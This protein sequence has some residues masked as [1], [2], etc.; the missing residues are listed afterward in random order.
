[1][2]DD[3]LVLKAAEGVDY[4]SLPSMPTPEDFY[5]LSR[6]KGE[7]S[8][9][10]L[11][12]ASGWGKD[13]AKA[14]I[15]KLLE[16]G[17]LVSDDF[18]PEAAAPATPEA[19]DEPAGESPIQQE[20]EVAE[21]SPVASASQTAEG[22]AVDALGNVAGEAQMRE[23]EAT[24]ERTPVV[25]REP[26]SAEQP[27]KK[28]EP[29]R[30]HVATP[31][32]DERVSSFDLPVIEE[33]EDDLFMS[34]SPAH[35]SRVKS[36]SNSDPSSP[37]STRPFDDGKDFASSLE[38][39]TNAGDDEIDAAAAMS[40]LEDPDAEPSFGND[41]NQTPGEK[42]SEPGFAILDSEVVQEEAD[43]ATRMLDPTSLDIAT[44]VATV[45]SRPVRKNRG[46]AAVG[47]ALAFSML[48]GELS[49]FKVAPELL[50]PALE[51]DPHARQEVAYV[52]SAIGKVTHYE[53]FGVS[54]EA[55]RKEI[56]KAYF[57]L[58]KRFHPDLYF[59]K[60]VGPFG[61]MVE[62]V[63]KAVTQAY[64]VLS[65]RKKRADYDQQ[66]K[67]RSAE[68][69]AAESQS[70]PMAEKRE[71]ARELLIKRASTHHA[72]GEFI[73][74]A[75]ALRK[76]ITIR[77]EPDLLVKLGNALYRAN[78]RLDDAAKY[79][80]SALREDPKNLDGMLV[81]AK[82]LERNEAYEDA[83]RVLERAKTISPDELSIGVHE[84][85][86]R[87]LMSEG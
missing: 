85:R 72:K 42:A 78:K 34:D 70:D 43:G 9:A 10:Q 20:D 56:K 74:A 66:L 31:V 83:L 87:N 40:A 79:C 14:T 15:Q 7:T 6:V 75:D 47:G 52:H 63:F 13:K 21:A 5:L 67:H 46:G 73:R 26:E 32:R 18:T 62:D 82:I 16:F 53:L 27:P 55:N 39:E 36:P 77:S 71:L 2:L 64:G 29:S 57:V 50:D 58:S 76:A 35:L 44:S 86:I 19:A 33:D 54:P 45:D 59:R 4:A 69:A 8:V 65:N 11:C 81:L 28:Q 49:E 24:P 68:P 84:E 12:A 37:S 60:N 38:A 80:R 48:P 25:E 30:D 51:I 23:R 17:L 3:E 61:P 1:M 22:P 41:G